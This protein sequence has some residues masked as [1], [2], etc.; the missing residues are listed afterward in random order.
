MADPFLFLPWVRQGVVSAIQD[1]DGVQTKL[2]NRARMDVTV[3]LKQDSGD[4]QKQT[5][6]LYGPGDVTGIDF[7]QIIRNVPANL[8]PAHARNQF[9][10]V[11]FYRPDFPWLY[12]PAKANQKQ[13][14]RPW[15]CLV[16]VEKAEKNLEIKTEPQQGGILHANAK[17][18]L[19]DLSEAWAWAHV[20]IAGAEQD[21]RDILEEKPDQNL[22]RLICARRLEAFKTYYACLV[23]T[24]EIG[25]L[26]GTGQVK[27]SDEDGELKPSWDNQTQDIDLPVY[28]FWEFTTGSADD[29]ESLVWSLRRFQA[30]AAGTLGTRP[31]K[32]K[33]PDPSHA[34]RWS[35][36]ESIPALPIEGALRPY[37]DPTQNEHDPLEPF[38]ENQDYKSFQEKLRV[39]INSLAQPSSTVVLPPD[40]P[41]AP[42]IYGR[43]HAAQR[44]IPDG[45]R[46]I[47]WLRELNLHPSYRAVAA[48]GTQIV[49]Q[50]QQHLMASA[51]EQVGEI[52][53]ANQVLR[54]AQ[55]A[56]SVSARIYDKRISP[57]AAETLIHFAA[58]LHS[59]IFGTETSKTLAVQVLESR[60]PQS[61]MSSAFRRLTR[62]RGPVARRAGNG[63]RAGELI[64]KL[65]EGEIK[66]V[67]KTRTPNGMIIMEQVFQDLGG[68]TE[69][70]KFCKLTP[71][72]IVKQLAV[73]LENVDLVNSLTLIR[74]RFATLN[75]SLLGEGAREAMLSAKDHIEKASSLLGQNDL[76]GF[77]ALL[78]ELTKSRD[79]IDNAILLYGEGSQKKELAWY[80]DQLASIIGTSMDPKDQ[81]VQ[82]ALAM[83]EQ[84]RDIEPCD[85]PA[86]PPKAKLPLEDIKIAL[87]ERLNPETTIQKRI[88]ARLTLPPAWQT[89]L[90]EDPEHVDGLEPILAA[91]TFPTPM[92]RALADLSQDLML[93]GLAQL[94][95]N[96]ITLLS[97]NPRFVEALMIGLHHEMSRELLWHGFPTD[98]RGLYF[99]QFWDTI[100]RVSSVEPKP[101]ITPI[102]SWTGALGKNLGG[103]SLNEQLV[104]LIRGDLLRLF[105]DVLIYAAQA[106]WV[107]DTGTQK[108]RREPAELVEDTTTGLPANE[109][110][111][112]LQ[113]KLLPDI[114]F[115]GFDIAP[116]TA[117]GKEGT[118]KPGDEGYFIVLQEQHTELSFGLELQAPGSDES[119]KTWQDLS[120][121]DVNWT[122]SNYLRA[123]P[124][125]QAIDVSSDSNKDLVLGSNSAAMAYIL[126]RKAFR[127]AIH[128]SHLL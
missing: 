67:D 20:Q 113:G 52:E 78:R 15:I 56:R 69:D 115:L 19:P 126:I 54:Q 74:T 73:I 100:G 61:M 44:A 110:Y 101:D 93:P 14:L 4:P 102:T 50:Q 106:K 109:K 34:D 116:A 27:A 95:P 53:K 66:V 35:E 120:W 38:K 99:P 48:I 37:W 5:V 58:A 98:Q 79:L 128:A 25:R 72:R 41:I 36:V 33:N 32:I 21:L 2:K 47:P 75:F 111:P 55:L 94:P 88:H 89:R 112:I 122:G 23:P 43:W 59:R 83:V 104:L 3:R 12:T 26:A 121:N 97:T 84:Q 82:F 28:Y 118:G 16:V 42:P 90:A 49:Q 114:R 6:R 57:Q 107:R 24:F 63:L 68:D 45:T 96:S 10:F 71:D 70:E 123:S 22:S 87:L 1:E 77:L 91:P 8:T 125:V 103:E 13:Q 124:L 92:Y 40:L 46:D 105:P 30:D 7:R 64:R 62:P 117:N 51:W 127:V 81:Q 76:E 11:E 86:I 60:V 17:A 119:T 108:W 18:E 65:N 29:F 85:A 80:R 39:L 31:A 9:P